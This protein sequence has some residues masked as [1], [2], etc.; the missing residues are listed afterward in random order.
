MA[1]DYQDDNTPWAGGLNGLLPP[2]V[3]SLLQRSEA[4]QARAATPQGAGGFRS[5]AAS[6]L[7]GLPG[8]YAAAKK[9]ETAEGAKAEELM[10]QR[11]AGLREYKPDDTA[12]YLSMA[13]HFLAP[14]RGGTFGESLSGVAGGLAPIVANEDALKEQYKQKALDIAYQASAEK[15]K[16]AGLDRRTMMADAVK[17]SQ[18]NKMQGI[19]ELSPEP[20]TGYPRQKENVGG[21]TF[22]HV[23][24]PT[25][26]NG[27]RS[28]EIIKASKTE[29]GA[30]TNNK[31]V[32]SAVASAIKRETDGGETDP[33]ILA[34][35]ARSEEA[36]ARARLGSF[37]TP[38]KVATSPSSLEKPVKWVGN[39]NETPRG[40]LGEISRISDPV[41]RA[42]AF[43]AYQD[44]GSGTNQATQVSP[45]EG[46]KLYTK[47][48]VADATKAAVKYNTD[49]IERNRIA[50]L[51]DKSLD[52]AKNALDKISNT[53][54]TAGIQSTLAYWNVALGN[55]T[56]ADK[57]LAMNA[58]DADKKQIDLAV[59]KMKGYNPKFTQMEFSEQRKNVMNKGMTHEAINQLFEEAK[60]EN[61]IPKEELAYFRE[62]TKGLETQPH[63]WV[64]KAINTWPEEL[65]KRQEA[66][67][68]NQEYSRVNIGDKSV[69]TRLVD[70]GD[71]TKVRAIVDEAGNYIL[72]AGGKPQV[73][74]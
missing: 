35:V 73:V 15:A 1:G 10:Q 51:S 63:K 32:A 31:I 57:K 53:G 64:E 9:L 52:E 41:D 44:S 38:E 21:R 54:K 29:E 22:V 13:Q 37:G 56:D 40:T 7:G 2:D 33:N 36:R 39:P 46:N 62:K 19:Q 42:A 50:A 30:D 28:S 26:P 3:T 18:M 45:S 16:Q 6:I 17:A 66:K 20:E 12:K 55:G 8:D 49:L 23:L 4:G 43:K 14:T 67:F 25:A 58:T 68:N 5:N 70:R 65:A 61:Q 11:M 24:D 72:G 71:G 60:S 34:A 69:R 27:I 48:A 47:A 59:A 74:K